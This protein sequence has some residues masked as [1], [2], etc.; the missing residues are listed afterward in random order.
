MPQL[1]Q[2]IYILFFYELPKEDTKKLLKIKVRVHTNFFRA[3]LFLSNIVSNKGSERVQSNHLNEKKIYIYIPRKQFLLL[4]FLFLSL[5]LIL[6]IKCSNKKNSRK[7]YSVNFANEIWCGVAKYKNLI[8]DHLSNDSQNYHQVALT[9]LW[10]SNADLRMY[11]RFLISNPKWL[12][13]TKLG[14]T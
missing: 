4:Q 3:I 5:F 2:I 7:K 10:I 12:T 8:I 11:Y 13:F 1:Y 14:W 6:V 9:S